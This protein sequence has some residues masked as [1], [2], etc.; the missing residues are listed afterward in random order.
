MATALGLPTVGNEGKQHLENLLDRSPSKGTF[1]QQ[2][3][4]GSVQMDRD[5]LRPR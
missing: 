2:Q 1:F 3:S 5:Y 4:A